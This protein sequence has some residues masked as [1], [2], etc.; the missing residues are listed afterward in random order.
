MSGDQ[1]PELTLRFAGLEICVRRRGEGGDQEAARSPLAGPRASAG[2]SADQGASAAAAASDSHWS[3][4]GSPE[5][6]SP[7]WREAVLD[8]T[9]PAELEALDIQPVEHLERRISEVCG[10]WSA[11]ARLGRA[12]RAGVAARSKLDG[13]AVVVSSPQ[14]NLTNHIY[15]VLRGAP[16]AGP[17]FCHTAKIYYQVVR[18][19]GSDGFHPKSVS[20]AFPSRAEAEAYAI[21]AQER[22]PLERRA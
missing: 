15:I 2:L 17:C 13:E 3:F 8:A 6:W 12:L 1:V 16:G 5:V 20:H 22:W 4:V 19:C 11:R 7:A 18:A 14:L 10:G 9:T 21:G